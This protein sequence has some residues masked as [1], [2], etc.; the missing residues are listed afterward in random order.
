MNRDPS[1][2]YT[3]SEAVAIG[4]FLSDQARVQAGDV[5]IRLTPKK[6]NPEPAVRQHS[7]ELKKR[8]SSNSAERAL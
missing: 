3:I 6:A 1:S 7:I 8:S 2:P 5:G 4:D